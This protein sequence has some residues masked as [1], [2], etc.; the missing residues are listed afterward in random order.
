M[1]FDTLQKLRA[2]RDDPRGPQGEREAA[3]EMLR[4]R[5]A[6]AGIDEADIEREQR[7]THCFAVNKG[8]EAAL[9]YHVACC[10]LVQYPLKP[11]RASRDKTHEFWSLSVTIA[12]RVDLTDCWEHYLVIYRAGLIAVDDEIKAARKAVAAAQKEFKRT[13][14][15]ARVMKSNMLNAVVNKYGLFPEGAKTAPVSGK[16]AAATAAAKHSLTGEKWA[17]KLPGEGQLELGFR[18]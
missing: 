17:R 15:A 12:E 6:A 13:A 18:S 3:A 5:L 10:I 1:N 7:E 11:V 16:A 2:L 8:K 4:K 9:F 14:K